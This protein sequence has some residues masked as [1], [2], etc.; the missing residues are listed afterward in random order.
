MRTVAQYNKVLKL[1]GHRILVFSTEV[2]QLYTLTKMGQ[3][4]DVADNDHFIVKQAKKVTHVFMKLCN[5][6]IAETLMSID[7]YAK[8]C[9]EADALIKRYGSARVG[10]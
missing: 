6:D 1:S 7:D 9:K 10:A 5:C 3:K 8:L 4:M 2:K